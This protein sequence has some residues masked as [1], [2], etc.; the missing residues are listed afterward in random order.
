MKYGMTLSM[1]IFG[2]ALILSGCGDE[3]GDS[4][5]SIDSPEANQP[6]GTDTTP[7]T[8]QEGT[9]TENNDGSDATPVPESNPIEEIECP[10]GQ[11]QEGAVCVPDSEDDLP[12]DVLDRIVG[13]YA[14]QMKIAQIQ[15]VPVLGDLDSVSTVYSFCDVR[16][17]DG[18][19][20]EIIERGCGAR[21][22]TGDAIEVVIPQAI[23][24]SIETEAVPLSV[25]MEGDEIKWSRPTVYVPVGIQLN[26]PENDTL[27]TDTSD[28]RIW[29]QDGD[30]NPGVTVNVSGFASG[31]IYVIQR[32]ISSAHGVFDGG[33]QLTGY[34]VDR[35]EQ[36]VIGASNPLLNQQI[37]SVPNPDPAQSTFR[38]SRMTEEVDCDWLL[39]NEAQV[40][41]AQ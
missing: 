25:W 23:P 16:A 36:V 15:T 27:P 41:P 2:L 18:G 14:I 40:F 1:T 39:T 24:R 32:Q 12:Q 37:V 4:N 7:E 30:G 34:V 17:A 5:G 13:T 20:L 22:S 10:D 9:P 19:G 38:T 6:A 29:D 33:D 11:S 28:P 35:S 26:D 31:E 8:N 3:S 21:S